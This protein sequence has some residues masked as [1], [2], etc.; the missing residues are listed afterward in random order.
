[1]FPSKIL[2]TTL[3]H[4]YGKHRSLTIK[5][6]TKES[7]LS[8][9]L[10]PLTESCS[11]LLIQGVVNRY[12]PGARKPVTITKI[13]LLTRLRWKTEIFFMNVFKNRNKSQEL[14]FS[15]QKGSGIQDLLSHSQFKSF[16]GVVFFVWLLFF[17]SVD[18][19]WLSNLQGERK[20]TSHYQDSGRVIPIASISTIQKG[21]RRD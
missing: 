21:I 16:L 8:A 7:L 18:Y 1:M 20:F 4:T 11:Q 17:T 13:Q 5:Q 15:I 12:M 9:C 14:R 2:C 3:T 6:K 19:I 10:E